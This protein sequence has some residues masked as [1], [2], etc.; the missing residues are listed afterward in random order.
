[1]AWNFAKSFGRISCESEHIWTK[2][3][4]KTEKLLL[5]K[6]I[7]KLNNKIDKRVQEIGVATVTKTSI[8]DVFD[9]VVMVFNRLF[10][11][12]S[13][14]PLSDARTYCI[15]MRYL[16]SEY[17]FTWSSNN[18]QSLRLKQETEKRWRNEWS[19]IRC[20]NTM[21]L[22]SSKMSSHEMWNTQN[23][24]EWSRNKTKLR[25]KSE[26][27]M[28]VR[29]ESISKAIDHINIVV[30]LCIHC[31]FQSEALNIHTYFFYRA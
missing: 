3:Y 17:V 31:Y 24:I 8:C 29:K 22:S 12:T 15:N 2:H 16:V 28:G 19:T 13:F 21:P 1:M 5:C 18:I 27:A 9:L 14:R 26:R 10:L 11:F 23:K 6:Q 25:D 4:A 20:A 30:M 7:H